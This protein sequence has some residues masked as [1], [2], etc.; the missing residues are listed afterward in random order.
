MDEGREPSGKA[1]ESAEEEIARL[2]EEQ[3]RLEAEVE[4]LRG[5]LAAPAPR[6]KGR[7][8]RI[9]TALLVLLT[10][11]VVTV[12]VAGVWARRNALN[13]D[14]WVETVTPIAAD[15]AVHEALGRWMTDELMAVIDLDALFESVLP[16]RGQILAVPLTNAVEGF[17]NDKIDEFLASDTFQ[18]L[19]VDLNRRAHDRVVA[20]LEG[21][22]GNLQIEDGEV[23]LNLVPVLNGVL[24]EIGKASPEILGRTVDLPTLTVEEVPKD[25]IEKIEDAT[26]LRIP[27]DWGQFT[28]FEAQ[29][30][31]Q[32]QDAV[33]LF[34]RFV[35]YVVVAAVVLLALTLWCSPH[36]RRTL[37]QL[38]VGIALGVVLIRR[39]GLRLEDDVVDLAKPENQDAVRVVVGAFVS[40]LLD[41]TAWILGGAAAIAAVAAITGPYRWAKA[42]R[43]GVASMARTAVGAVGAAAKRQPDDPTV[44]WVGEH[45]EC[46]RWAASSWASSCCS[47]STCRGS[48]FCCSRCWSAGSSSWCRAS[49]RSRR[50][51]R[52][53]QMAVSP[54]R[55][56]PGRPEPRVEQVIADA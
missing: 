38:M 43:H 54:K 27:D 36:R 14:R 7:P 23:V 12:A 35:V 46:S 10:S 48:A 15:P 40:S 5:Q 56:E 52:R 50:P 31:E 49:P 4:D 26:G 32:A 47:W 33:D 42:L 1:A 21:D 18:R 53:R 11:L 13:T 39:L 29:R 30:L 34:N 44:V 25:A 41:A 19:W 6:R 37:L 24:A 55:H 17:V 2:A 28:V 9:V 8:R 16:E 45:K 51:A 3:A 22:T 20:V